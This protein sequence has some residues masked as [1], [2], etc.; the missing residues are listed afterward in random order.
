MSNK[1]FLEIK[2]IV[3]EYFIFLTLFI[4]TL[5]IYYYCSKLK[6]IGDTGFMFFTEYCL[7]LFSGILGVINLKDLIE[8]DIG[9]IL[10]TI[11]GIERK[12]GVR[13]QFKFIILLSILLLFYT[14]F[15]SIIFSELDFTTTF[16]Q[17]V[18]R[19]L[20]MNSLGFL[21][22]VFFKNSGFAIACIGIYSILYY[23]LYFIIG[24][25]FLK[26][27]NIYTRSYVPLHGEE[28][29]LFSIKILIFSIILYVCAQINI[30]YTKNN[31]R[32]LNN[33]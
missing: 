14:I 22:I 4:I 31:I 13:R 9:E 3:K 28:I 15:S 23:F 8:D 12:I 5:L 33:F 29:I 32:K 2:I 17:L 26:T 21:L 10:F 18:S 7:T 20:F 25:T 1:I 11:K 27:F 6:N 19:C 30:T 24:D 16:I